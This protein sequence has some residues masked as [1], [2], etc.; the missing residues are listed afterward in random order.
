VLHDGLRHEVF[1][2]ADERDFL[3]GTAGFIHAALTA[4]QPILVAVDSAKTAAL[5]TLVDDETDNVQFADIAAV[6]RNPARV[7]PLLQSFIDQ[8]GPT[9]AGVRGIC[10]TVWPDRRPPELVECRRSEQL[11]NDVFGDA[12]GFWLLCPYDSS[13]LDRVVI[14]DAYSTHPFI[15][16]A[17]QSH[18]SRRYERGRV[19]ALVDEPLPEPP[20]GAVIVE[21]SGADLGSVRRLVTEHAVA[22]GLEARACDLALATDELA[23]NSVR[24]AGGQGVLRLWQQDRALV[25]EVNDQGHLYDRLVGRR[26]P[27]R[28]QLGGRGLW[29][30]NQLTDLVQIRSAPSGTT[31]RVHLWS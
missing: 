13:A 14:D 30:V 16:R 25:I 27:T 5:R 12:A 9:S 4:R 29:L 23:T 11:L 3:A 15:D 8:H 26:R 10:E 22:A 2:Y 19:A 1:L 18:V 24:H 28:S 31:V 17:G 7:I 20:V 6:G 21:F